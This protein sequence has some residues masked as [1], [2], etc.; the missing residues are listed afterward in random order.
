MSINT[1]PQPVR[2]APAAAPRTYQD[3]TGEATAIRWPD[4]AEVHHT[5]ELPSPA[6]CRVQQWLR[7]H[8]PPHWGLL[9]VHVGEFET[10]V[11][12]GPLD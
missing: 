9:D 3:P 5:P 12:F 7:R 10:V 1:G 11:T 4:R 2:L 6:A 8:L